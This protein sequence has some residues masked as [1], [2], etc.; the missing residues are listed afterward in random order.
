MPSNAPGFSL[1]HIPALYFAFAHISPLITSPLFGTAWTMA[2]Y[3]LPQRIVDVPESWP[4]WEAGQGRTIL[5]GLLMHSFYWRRQ[6]AAC[7]TILIGVAFLGLNDFWLL[8][9]QEGGIGGIWA[10]TRRE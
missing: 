2:L 5:L 10:W 9:K 7:D 3:G 1:R 4:A 8:W 6:Y